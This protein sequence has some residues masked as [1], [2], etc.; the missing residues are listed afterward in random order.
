MVSQTLNF[1]CRVDLPRLNEK[2][3]CPSINPRAESA[4]APCLRA[5]IKLAVAE[6]RKDISD[7]P[8][9][10]TFAD[11]EFEPQSDL[12]ACSKVHQTCV[13]LQIDQAAACPSI[14][15]LLF[16]EGCACKQSRAKQDKAPQLNLLSCK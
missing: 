9:K 6:T 11:G 13:R 12:A 5:A 15:D 8:C 10:W 16:E 14:D 2:H 1:I 3:D 4:D 7:R